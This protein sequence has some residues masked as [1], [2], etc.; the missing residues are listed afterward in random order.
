MS[1]KIFVLTFYKL[2]SI[3][4][5]PHVEV[6]IYG[7]LLDHFTTLGSYFG[8]KIQLFIL[9]TVIHIFEFNILA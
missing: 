6:I 2:F 1:L 7:P 4:V 5:M 3:R 8:Q 9:N